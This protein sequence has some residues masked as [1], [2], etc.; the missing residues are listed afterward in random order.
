MSK[1]D[2]CGGGIRFGGRRGKDDSEDAGCSRKR[3]EERKGKRRGDLRERKGQ[4]KMQPCRK[5]QC[6]EQVRSF[7][8]RVIPTCCLGRSHACATR[9]ER[10]CCHL[11]HLP[12]P[13]ATT[14]IRRSLLASLLP[15]FFPRSSFRRSAVVCDNAPSSLASGSLTHTSAAAPSPLEGNTRLPRSFSFNVVFLHLLSALF[16]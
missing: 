1:E 8:L 6:R 12:V 4:M 15:S 9:G 5:E 11:S 2:G 3:S 7:L 13:P 16:Y 10:R 14:L